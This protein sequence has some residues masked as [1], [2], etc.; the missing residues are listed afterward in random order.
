VQRERELW[1]RRFSE[2]THPP[3][4]PDP[5]LIEAHERYVAPAFPNGGRVLD[6][7]GGLGRHALFY[8]RKGW[9]A[10][11]IDIS[12]VAAQS[13]TEITEQEKLS[14][15]IYTADLD[16]FRWREWSGQFDLV[17]V[18]FYLQRQLF[19]ALMNLLRSGG[20]LIYKTHLRSETNSNSAPSNP[21]H[22]LEPG[23]L[24]RAFAEMQ[25]LHHREQLSKRSTA[26]LVARK[27]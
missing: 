17:L 1:N 21:L 26:E 13:V 25:I 10:T 4:E 27:K 18:F 7:A 5:F 19:P 11:L 12:E 15:T 16:E 3:A 2:G 22:V 8:A 23:E 14:L 24:Q 6:I 9:Q 20:L